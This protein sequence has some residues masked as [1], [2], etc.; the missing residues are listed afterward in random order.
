MM[1]M[2]MIPFLLSMKKND[3]YEE[4]GINLEAEMLQNTERD[5]DSYDIM[6]EEELAN[7]DD[8]FDNNEMTTNDSFM[9]SMEA[10]ELQLQ[11]EMHNVHH[12]IVSNNNSSHAAPR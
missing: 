2:I 4:I 8:F 9:R 1:A 6:N 12:E 7:N 3:N 11:N 10:Y 5:D